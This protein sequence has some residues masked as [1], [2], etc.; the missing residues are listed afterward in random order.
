MKFRAGRVQSSSLITSSNNLMLS[1]KFLILKPKTSSLECFYKKMTYYQRRQQWYCNFILGMMYL[2]W[3]C[4]F[5]YGSLPSNWYCDK[6]TSLF[7]VCMCVYFLHSQ[8]SWMSKHLLIVW[9][10][11]RIFPH[12]KAKQLV[13][14][15]FFEKDIKRN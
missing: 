7:S 2:K 4:I 13:W 6:V 3:Q 5:F 1:N 9:L 10:W 14:C 11:R 15:F 8:H 12:Q